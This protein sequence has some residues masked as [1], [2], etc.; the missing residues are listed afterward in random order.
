MA[1]EVLF[2][3]PLRKLQREDVTFK[4]RVDG[5]KFGELRVSKGSIVWFPKN[6]SKGHKMGWKKFD[7]MMQEFATRVEK[8][9]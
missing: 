7:K 2:D 5:E 3:I 6:R 9:R 1:H 4:V 8:K